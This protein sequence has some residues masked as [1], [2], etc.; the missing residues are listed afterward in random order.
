M[1]FI[2]DAQL[3]PQLAVWL[4]DKGCSAKSLWELSLQGASDLVVWDIAVR[5]NA[6]IVTK[7]EDFARLAATR[8]GPRVLWVR[9]GNLVNRILLGRFETAWPEITGHLL[10]EARVVELR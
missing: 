6:I 4:R 2:V 3:P 10:S 9:C 1:N 5:E 7:D 8:P